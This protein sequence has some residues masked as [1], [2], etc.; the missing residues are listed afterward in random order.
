MQQQQH[1]LSCKFFSLSLLFFSNYS[2]GYYSG[3]MSTEGGKFIDDEAKN[4]NFFQVFFFSLSLFF[5]SSLPILFFMA[6][7][8]F[9]FPRQFTGIPSLVIIL[10][11]WP[12]TPHTHII[13]NMRK[14]REKHSHDRWRFADTYW[15]YQHNHHTTHLSWPINILWVLRVTLLTSLGH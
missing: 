15:P 12:H 4:L 6:Q 14:K 1:K 9:L 10:L 8:M 5:S 13:V 2:N 3:N 7:Q 11:P